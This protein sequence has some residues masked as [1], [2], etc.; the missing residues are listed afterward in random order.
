MD[1]DFS[2]CNKVFIVFSRQRLLSDY[3]SRTNEM[4]SYEQ[5]KNTDTPGNEAYHCGGPNMPVYDLV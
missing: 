1:G 4:H 3:V 5:C 2:Y